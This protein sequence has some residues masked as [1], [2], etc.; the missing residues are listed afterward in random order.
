MKQKRRTKLVN[1]KK[2]AIAISDAKTLFDS[3]MIK[4]DA[5]RLMAARSAA[6]EIARKD[7][8]KSEVMKKIAKTK[9]PQ[10]KKPKK[11]PEVKSFNVFKRIK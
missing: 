10:P 11:K 2:K 8:Q 9:I 7:K 1:P 5:E 4:A 3:E 6:I